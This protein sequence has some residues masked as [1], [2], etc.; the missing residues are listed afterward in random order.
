MKRGVNCRALKAY[1]DALCRDVS[2]VVL[3]NR[4]AGPFGILNILDERCGGNFNDI[5][6]VIPQEEIDEYMAA[7]KRFAGFAMDSLNRS[8]PIIEPDARVAR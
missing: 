3:H 6:H 4:E 7:Y 5:E 1:D 8:P 2:A